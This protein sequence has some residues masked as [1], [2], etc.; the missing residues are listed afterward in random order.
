[1]MKDLRSI[2]GLPNESFGNQSWQLYKQSC[3][4]FPLTVYSSN[5]EHENCNINEFE[6]TIMH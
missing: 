1:M 4:S 3:F 5:V 2:T 6:K